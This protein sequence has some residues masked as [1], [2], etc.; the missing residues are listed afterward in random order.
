MKVEFILIQAKLGCDKSIQ[1]SMDDIPR[2]GDDV[3]LQFPGMSSDTYTV[4]RVTY[5]LC[6]C[7]PSKCD[8][9]IEVVRYNA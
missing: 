5:D 2:K 9:G 7:S 4:K 1:F 8:V 6:H 3:H